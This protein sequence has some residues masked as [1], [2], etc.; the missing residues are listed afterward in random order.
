MATQISEQNLADS[1]SHLVS[2]TVDQYHQMIETAILPEG[3]QIELLDGL[4]VLKDRRDRGGNPMNVGSRHSAV[5]TQLTEA[6]R[7]LI[8]TVGLHVRCQQPITL[9]PS[10]E[11]EPDVAIVLGKPADYVKRNPEPPDILAVMEVAD[12]SLRQDRE[13]K[14]R[15]YTNAGIETYWIID[16][17]ADQ[18][19][20]YTQPQSGKGRYGQMQTFHPGEMIPLPLP[21][22]KTTEMAVS[23]VLI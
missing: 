5:V 23:D 17:T 18:I 20:V 9:P 19:E 2:F 7:D 3:S 22:G 15:I 10:N 14:Q 6:I 16:L 12:S 21:S 8:G 1:G 11:P 13:L 4:L